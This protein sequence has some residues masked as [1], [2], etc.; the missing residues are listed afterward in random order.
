[1]T[2]EIFLVNNILPILL[3]SVSILAV[4]PCYLTLRIF[5]DLV[6]EFLRQLTPTRIT[7]LLC[8]RYD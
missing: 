8:N 5:A 6:K 7:L 4:F 2:L 1:M 3:I